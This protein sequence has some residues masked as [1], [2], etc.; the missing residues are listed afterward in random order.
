MGSFYYENGV[1]LIP[2]VDVGAN[3]GG[4]EGKKADGSVVVCCVG[5]GMSVHGAQ[6][7]AFL[8]LDGS[9]DDSALIAEALAAAGIEDEVNHSSVGRNED[10]N[11]CGS[12]SN[13]V[14]TASKSTSQ[15]RLGLHVGSDLLGQ[16]RNGGSGQDDSSVHSHQSR[17]HIVHYP[18]TAERDESVH[19]MS[20]EKSKFSTLQLQLDSPPSHVLLVRSPH[21]GEVT[22]DA[23]ATLARE[24]IVKYSI[25][26]VTSADDAHALETQYNVVVA[27]YASERV[28]A[29]RFYC[30]ASPR[31]PMSAMVP[32]GDDDGCGWLTRVPSVE[33]RVY[34]KY[35]RRE[36]S[37]ADL[38]EKI[39]LVV[40]LGGDG[41]LL[42]VCSELFYTKVPPILGFNFGSLGFLTPFSIDQAPS[43]AKQ[44]FEELTVPYTKRMRLQCTLYRLQQVD[45]ESADSATSGHIEERLQQEEDTHFIENEFH[46]TNEVVID[47]GPAAYLTNLECFCDGIFVTRVQADGL[48]IATPTGSTAYSLSAG[49]SMVHPSVPCILF[50]PICPHSLSFRPVLFPDGVELKLCVPYESRTSAWISFDG[51]NRLEMKRGDF[52]LVR[53][54]LYPLRTL[55][56]ENPISD[57]FSA[58]QR[59]LRWNERESQR[60]FS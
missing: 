33:N 24:L 57:W 4:G 42:Y 50:T 16:S 56:H 18:S 46:V 13:S 38:E 2:A 10:E 59:C 12:T 39:G 36:F 1:D 8:P 45:A 32:G 9:E 27:N 11:S 3:W 49:G 6:R 48:I 7:K 41:L 14:S 43:V 26:V 25:C 20:K 35:A 19:I 58:I 30:V 54:S 17:K 22:L 55:N 37:L 44:V 5:L 40:G 15:S 29:G 34:S 51:R 52:I 60:K 47:R 28:R 21:T 31:V 53:K 23:I